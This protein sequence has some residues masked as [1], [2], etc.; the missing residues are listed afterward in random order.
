M[1]DVFL[2]FSHLPSSENTAIA[3]F[4]P[5]GINKNIQIC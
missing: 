5:T 4:Q 1:T 2:Y 3:R